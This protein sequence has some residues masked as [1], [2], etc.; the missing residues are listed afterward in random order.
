M[1]QT[2][3]TRMA[4][5]ALA[6]A[7]LLGPAS[8]RATT[9]FTDSFD[10]ANGNLAGKSGG[11]G[12]SGAWT[13]GVSQ[14]AG[15]LPGT[16]GNSVRFSSNASVTSRALVGTYTTGGAASYYLSFLFNAS[17]IP[18]SG[19]GEYAGVSLIGTTSSF[20]AGVPGS[21]GQL[22]FDWANEGDGLLTGTSGT[23]YLLL[24]E[25]KA[26]GSAGYT[27]ANFYATTDLGATGS[28]LLAGAPAAFL[29]GPNFSFSS[30]EIAGGYNSGSVNLAGL[31]M[32]TSADESVNLTLNVVPEA[33][34]AGWMAAALLA[35]AGALRRRQ[36]GRAAN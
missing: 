24:F 4:G 3:A 36:K 15:G 23:N 22:G 8:S 32:T 25:F 17:P 21:S 7:T 27:L 30:V 13:G 18:P 12:W 29:E 28:S 16:S 1:R 33:S 9:V 34:T 19:A 11:S 31:A 6:A 10:Y 26:G 2:R 35:G 20:F 14:V 5:L